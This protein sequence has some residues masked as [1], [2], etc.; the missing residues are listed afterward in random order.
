MG[1]LVLPLVLLAAFQVPV[2]PP[3]PPP[4]QPGTGLPRDGARDSAPRTGTAVIRGKVTDQETGEPI[5]RAMVTI[6]SST[7]SRP[8][9]T[10]PQNFARPLQATTGSDGRFE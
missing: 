2:P 3:P 4:P 9:P 7:L 1:S 8:D 5:P 10:N 6:S